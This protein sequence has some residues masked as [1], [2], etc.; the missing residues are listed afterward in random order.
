[1]VHF[2]VVLVYKYTSFDY[3]NESFFYRIGDYKAVWLS[4]CKNSMYV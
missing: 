4:Y 3:D 1:M 2:D